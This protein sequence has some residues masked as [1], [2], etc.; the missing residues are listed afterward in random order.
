VATGIEEHAVGGRA[1]A[2]TAGAALPNAREMGRPA[3]FRR[4]DRVMTATCA[5]ADR[6]R[7]ANAAGP[8]EPQ[9]TRP[10]ATRRYPGEQR[11]SPCNWHAAK[12]SF[13]ADRPAVAHVTAALRRLPQGNARRRWARGHR[14]FRSGG[15]LD[16][17]V[18]SVASVSARW[19]R[20]SRGR[21]TGAD[22]R[23]RGP[24]CDVRSR[25]TALDS[26]L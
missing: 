18:R 21:P 3:A 22:L 11:I 12:G 7:S 13:C 26:G 4:R 1:I 20:F 19:D 24:R 9:R 17:F 25:R 2:S 10:V 23:R 14:R 6:T 8:F 16:A 15:R 5:D